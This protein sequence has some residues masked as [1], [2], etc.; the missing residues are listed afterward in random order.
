MYQFRVI[1]NERMSDRKML[2][3]VNSWLDT[4]KSASKGSSDHSSVSSGNRLSYN[5][6][7]REFLLT[8]SAIL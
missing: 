7:E 3:I 2:G 4:M 5:Q 8:S 1:I 6:Y